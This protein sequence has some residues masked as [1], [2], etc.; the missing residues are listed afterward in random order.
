MHNVGCLRYRCCPFPQHWTFYPRPLLSP[1]S[2]GHPTPPHHFKKSP[3]DILVPQTVDHRVE[4][5]SEDIIKEGDLLVS[6]RGI[7]GVGSYLDVGGWSIEESDHNQVGSTGGESLAAALSGLDLENGL[8]NT[9]VGGQNEGEW[10]NKHE[11]TDDQVCHLN[12]VGIHASQ[13]PY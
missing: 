6:L 3:L 2:P 13:A 8:S 7:A 10:G 1:S 4:Q 5:G 12:E 9:D 11:D